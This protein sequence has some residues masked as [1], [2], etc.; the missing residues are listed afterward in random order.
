MQLRSRI[1]AHFDAAVAAQPAAFTC[2]V[3]CD[4]CCHRRFSVFEVEAAR[5]REALADLENNDPEHRSRIREQAERVPH[6]ALLVDGRCSVYAQRPTICRSHGLAV[7]D[8]QGEGPVVDWC[9]LNFKD[10]A[11]ARDGILN[12]HAVNQPLAVVAELWSPG[13]SRVALSDLAQEK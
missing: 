2:A 1:D 11:P 9:P 6:C 7:L 4:A 10:E 3:G 13:G 8:D 12:L 5:I